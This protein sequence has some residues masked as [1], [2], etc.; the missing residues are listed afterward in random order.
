MNYSISLRGQKMSV[1]RKKI[2]LLSWVGTGEVA[3]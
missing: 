2:A 3:L 1:M